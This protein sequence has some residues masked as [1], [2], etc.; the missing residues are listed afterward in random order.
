MRRVFA[1]FALIAFAF[2][3]AAQQTLPTAQASAV[4]D[5]LNKAIAEH[6]IPGASAAV[7][8]NGAIV[9]TKG[10]GLAD[11]EEQVPA[12][13]ETEYRLGS[14]SKPISAVA[15][16]TLVQQHK[17]DLDAPVQKYCPAFPQKQWPVTTREVLSHTS[18][19]RHYRDDEMSSVWAENMIT[20]RSG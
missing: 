18:G 17:L 13:P 2:P 4:E 20:G 10:F 15:A 7:V 5:I 8:E 19:I 12:R 11:V 14:V 9:W 1:L 16:M 6:Q 3:A